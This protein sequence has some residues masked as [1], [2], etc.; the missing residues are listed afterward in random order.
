VA[1]ESIRIPVIG[2]GM[3]P[4]VAF[5]HD[6]YAMPALKP[7]IALENPKKHEKD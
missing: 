1:A 3:R 5:A 7:C 2:F 4:G 6:H